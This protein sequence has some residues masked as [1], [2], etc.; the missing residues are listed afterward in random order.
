MKTEILTGDLSAAVQCLKEGGLVAVP[1]ETVY[2]LSADGLNADA[3]KKLYDV[4]GRPESK[5][6]NLLVPDMETVQRFCQDIPEEAFVLA[7]AFW[8]G[9]LTIILHKRE[10]VPPIVTA[11]GDTVGVRCPS[12]P[13][14]LSLLKESCIPLATPSANLSGQP[15]PKNA[16]QVLAYFEGKIPFIIDGGPCSVGIESTIVDLTGP[17]PTILRQGGLPKEELEK[18]LGREVLV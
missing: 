2:G 12:H 5:P 4:K 8:P 1:T 7:A 6:I 3:V 13:L 15:S 17:V 10:N 16:G 9:P 18:K 11:S 14:T